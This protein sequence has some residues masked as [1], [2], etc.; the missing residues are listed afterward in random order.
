[1]VTGVVVAGS[2]TTP[3]LQSPIFLRSWH[4]WDDHGIPR[5][6]APSRS[7]AADVRIAGARRRWKAPTV[8][9]RR[10]HGFPL[11]P[12]GPQGP[13]PRSVLIRRPFI[14]WLGGL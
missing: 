7:R 5:L 13:T 1:M 11:R 4:R 9:P 10:R 14:W 2:D 3:W 8:C 12:R 6:G